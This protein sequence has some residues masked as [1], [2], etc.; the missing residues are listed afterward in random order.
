MA[1][2]FRSDTNASENGKA[3]AR[4]QAEKH[5]AGKKPAKKD[6]SKPRILPD[7]LATDVGPKARDFDHHYKTALGLKSKVEE[8]NGRYRAALKAAKEAGINPAVITATMGWAKK[9]PAEAQIYFKQLRA[10]FETA[11]IEVQLSM[12][13]EASVSRS[14]QIYD[15]GF[16]AGKAGKSSTDGPHDLNTPAGQTWMQGWSAGQAE[17]MAGIGK[18]P[19]NDSRGAVPGAAH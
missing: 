11:G 9:D 13:D 19:A 8:A 7:L 18:T 3:R 1:K 4:A 12:F 6:E 5:F 10:T 16:K 15:D 2:R 17:N 14:A